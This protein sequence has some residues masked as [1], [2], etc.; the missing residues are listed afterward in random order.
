MLTSIPTRSFNRRHFDNAVMYTRSVSRA[1]LDRLVR[2][3]AALTLAYIYLMD[4]VE[5]AWRD[6]A[7]AAIKEDPNHSE[8]T[9]GDIGIESIDPITIL[10]YSTFRL[11]EAKLTP[12]Q[13]PEEEERT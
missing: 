7:V 4:E 5:P 11:I 8:I 9:I 6:L 2:R 10:S 1:H 3:K 12:R 13:P